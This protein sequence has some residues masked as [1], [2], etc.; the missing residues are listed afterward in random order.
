MAVGA[1][2]DLNAIASTGLAVYAAI[3]LLTLPVGVALAWAV[4]W[5]AGAPATRPGTCAS[6]RCSSSLGLAA[7][8][9]LGLF[10]NLLVAQQRWDLQ[11]LGNFVSTVLYAALVALLMPCYGGLILLGALTLGTTVASP[12]DSAVL[13]AAGAAGAPGAAQPRHACA[14][15]ASLPRSARRT[16]SSTSRRRSSSRP[17]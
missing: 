17:T 9:P 2:G 5:I 4:P 13:A 15:S 12:R 8:F 7:R 3:G 11:N 6:R 10:N 1:T 16:S 14:A